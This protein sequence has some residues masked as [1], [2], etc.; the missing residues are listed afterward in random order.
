[1]DLIKV[2]VLSVVSLAVLLLLTKIMGNKQV[3]QLSI[4]D[5]IIGISIGSIAAEMATDLENPMRSLLAMII[6]GLIAFLVS[7]VTGKSAKTR[8]VVIGRPLILYDNGKLYRNNFSKARIDIS[9]FLMQCRN[10]GY[11]DLNDIQTAVFE[12]NGAVSILP[13]EGTRPLTPEDMKL[14]PQQKHILVN[15]ILDG[16]INPDN[17]KLTGNNEV[18]LEKQLHGQGFHSTEEIFL[19]TVDTTDNTLSLYPIDTGENRSD[20]FE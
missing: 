1:M 9:D 2:A 17:L 11:F 6:Y 20:P 13:T 7:L 18:W 19:G 15:V 10:Q 14:S 8:K 5:Y 4:F 16:H 3:S 12:Y